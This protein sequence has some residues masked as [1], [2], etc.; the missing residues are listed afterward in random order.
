MNPRKAIVALLMAAGA[1]AAFAQPSP[2]PSCAVETSAATYRKP[3]LTY[4][5]PSDRYAVQYSLDGGGWTDAKVY[6]SYY[7]GTNA[8]P[9]VSYSGYTP[10][11]SM[12]FVSIPAGANRDVQLHVTSCGM[13]LF[14]R[15]IACRPGPP[16]RG[17]MPI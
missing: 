3:P 17:S 10:E 13:H 5:M 6:I 16:S 9:L 15:A 4:P 14:W 12:S 8:S 7:G 2:T 1:S 11:T